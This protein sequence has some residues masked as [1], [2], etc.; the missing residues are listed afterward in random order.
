MTMTD[1]VVVAR[2]V[3]RRFAAVPVLRGVDL[4][5][6][7][8]TSVALFGSNGAGKTTLLRIIAG[9]MRAS[10]GSVCVFGKTLRDD[11]ALRG[12]IGVVAHECFLYGDLSARENLA[13]YARLY[14]VSDQQRG[15]R[16]LE[17]LGLG[18]AADR[19]VRTYSR[20]MLQRLALARA[21]LHRPDLLLLDEPFT[22]LDPRGAGLL[23]A[24]LA[25]LR[26]QQVTIILTTHDFSRGLAAAD[27]VVL[28]H[29]GRVA[30]RSTDK[31]PDTNEMTRI[32][33]RVVANE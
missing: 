2:G 23:A 9:L 25:E 5:I 1:S 12:R 30:W 18:A 31:L 26:S 14:R 10:R 20:G 13:Y 4:D 32:Y 15:E 29:G 3:E 8:G 24:M 6:R 27:A 22:G 17:E 7:R 16:L 21:V 28:L 19:P 33:D 11:H